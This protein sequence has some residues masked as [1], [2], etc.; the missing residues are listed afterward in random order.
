MKRILIS[1]LL[2]SLPI[3]TLANGS[4][5]QIGTALIKYVQY[6]QYIGRNGRF[7]EPKCIASRVLPLHENNE[8]QH[9]MTLSG[10][11]TASINITPQVPFTEKALVAIK[12]CQHDDIDDTITE[13]TITHLE[14][15][16]IDGGCVLQEIP[17]GVQYEYEQIEVRLSKNIYPTQEISDTNEPKK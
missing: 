17:G 15:L 1:L 7:Y 12:F 8:A 5:R 10:R 11:E 16:D 14:P 2:C 9:T 6:S 13:T 4:A 3:I